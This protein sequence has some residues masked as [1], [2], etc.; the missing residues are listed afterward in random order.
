MNICGES[1]LTELNIALLFSGVCGL[2]FES[3]LKVGAAPTCLDNEA[4]SRFSDAFPFRGF[5][6]RRYLQSAGGHAVYTNTPF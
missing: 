1:S 6:E 4:V 3:G 5:K 2:W